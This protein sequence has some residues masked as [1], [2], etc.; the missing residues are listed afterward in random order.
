MIKTQSEI[1][2]M[3]ALPQ[4]DRPSGWAWWTTAEMRA[5]QDAHERAEKAALEKYKADRIAR[6][7]AENAEYGQPMNRGAGWC[8]KCQSH[9]YSDCRA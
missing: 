6:I 3:M 5:K 7:A 1:D 8:N 2:A 9:C 4:G